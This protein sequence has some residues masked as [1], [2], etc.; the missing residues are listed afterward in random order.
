MKKCVLVALCVLVF[1]STLA[2]TGCQK[3]AE[4]GR[5]NQSLDNT[6]LIGPGKG[7]DYGFGAVGY[8]MD[9]LIQRLGPDN[10]KKLKIGVE[11]W[12]LTTQWLI[13]Y[14]D[15]CKELAKQYG[16]EVVIL[17]ADADIQKQADDFKSFQNMQVDG[18]ITY[19]GNAAAIAQ[20]LTEVNQTIPIISSVGVLPPE[21]KIAGAINVSEEAKGAM[22]VDKIAEEANGAPRYILASCASIDFPVLNDR[23][24]GFKSQISKYP[25]LKIV[26]ESLAE[27]TETNFLDVI[28]EGLLAHEEVDTTFGSFSW[29]IMGAYNGGKQLNRKLKI[30]GCDAD[31]AMLDLLIAGDMITGL[32]VNWPGPVAYL[33]LFNLFRVL[34]GEKIP[35]ITYEPEL[36]A[37]YFCSQKDGPKVKQILYGK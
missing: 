16:F 10:V 21:V 22:L 30:Y 34:G 14:T 24:K 32:Q 19:L 15:E 28:K 11:V 37:K 31:E 18:I 2:V 36:Y 8:D 13:Q 4:T 1:L 9:G 29:P 27:G 26:V 35:F 33:S 5:L 17:S 3:K 25:N 20:V 7:K 6:D 23:L 12:G